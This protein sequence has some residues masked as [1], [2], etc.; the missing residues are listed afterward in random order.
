MCPFMGGVAAF[1]AATEGDLLAL[2]AVLVAHSWAAD[3]E[4]ERHP[5]RY[6]LHAAVAA[7]QEACVALLLRHGASIEKQD[8]QG[9][10]PLALA[11]QLKLNAVASLLEAK[12]TVRALLLTPFAHLTRAIRRSPRGSLSWRRSCRPSWP[13]TRGCPSARRWS[14]QSLASCLCRSSW[15]WHSSSISREQRGCWAR[16]CTAS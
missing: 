3:A 14:S 16:G 7:G 5:Q 13:E 10:T 2:Q 1:K 6:V 15:Q 12:P 11:K 4:L 9:R 8:A